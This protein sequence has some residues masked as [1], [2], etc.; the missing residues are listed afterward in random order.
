MIYFFFNDEDRYLV[1]GNR[2]YLRTDGVVV[3]F[4]FFF[5]YGKKKIGENYI[6][7]K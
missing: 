1:K 3:F 6:E 7:K 2:Q 4:F 5:F